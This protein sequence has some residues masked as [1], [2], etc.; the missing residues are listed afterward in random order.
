MELNVY[1][2]LILLSK[3]FASVQC[4]IFEND[5]DLVIFIHLQ[6]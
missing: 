6:K 1:V 4:T 3:V 5:S 2:S